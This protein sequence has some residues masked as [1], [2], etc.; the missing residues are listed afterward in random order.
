MG[1]EVLGTSILVDR[2]PYGGS[3]PDW[4]V[5]ADDLKRHVQID[6]D[7]DDLLLTFGAGGYLAAAVENVESRGQISLMYQKRKQV[8][9]E[10]PSDRS[11]HINRGPLIS[12]T[13]ITY[14][15]GNDAEQTLDPSYYRALAA[16]RGSC[17]YFKGS[18]DGIT[19]ASGPGVVTIN[20]ICGMGDQAD[21]IPAAWRQ[22]VAELAAYF[23]ER[24]DGVAGGGIDE[25]MEAVF[26]RKVTLAGAVRRY[27]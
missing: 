2:F 4:P 3:P 14:L 22:I 10:L 20:C 18:T 26:D 25:A 13:S 7:E 24:R 21:K 11:V 27:V 6:H 12:V 23:Y 17:V 15:D 1:T 16:G 8:L 5:L 9:D 19:V